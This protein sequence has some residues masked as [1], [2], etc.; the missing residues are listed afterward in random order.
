MELNPRKSLN[1]KRDELKL[2]SP[3][4][5]AKSNQ[6][7]NMQLIDRAIVK[8]FKPKWYAVIHYND[9]GS[10][11]K[12]QQRRIDPFDVEKD[13]EE[14][15]KQLYVELYGRNWEKTKNRSKS[16]WGIEYGRSQ[17]KPHI[18][19][20]IEELPFPFDD[21]RSFFVLL[22]RLLPRAIKCLW[23]RSAYL[24]PIDMDTFDSL[25]SY[26]CKES[27]FRNCNL[28]YSINDFQ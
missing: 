14:V 10:S 28:A 15:R 9:G 11:K 13:L 2:Q 3:I 16:I 4:H 20:I 12:Y 25:N 21:Y 22:D 6:S 23:R 27:D 7:A 24:Q 17:H 18:N 1:Q 19:L 5:Y 8:G 26:C